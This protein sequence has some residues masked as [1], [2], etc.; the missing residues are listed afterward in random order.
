MI[1]TTA[2]LFDS[3]SQVVQAVE[4][5]RGCGFS[6]DEISMVTQK[7]KAHETSGN[8]AEPKDAASK[9]R[10]ILPLELG[11]FVADSQPRFMKGIGS[12]VMAGPLAFILMQAT[13]E[14]QC[15]DLMDALI[16]LDLSDEEAASYAEG[17]RRGG[18]LLTVS[19]ASYLAERAEDVMLLNGA[20]DIRQR[21]LRWQQHGWDTFSPNAEPCTAEEM[22]DERRRQATE[23]KPGR[24]WN[25]YDR[26][27]RSHFY[28][29]YSDGSLPYEAYAPAYRYGYQLASDERYDKKD[30]CEIEAHALQDWEK[31][32]ETGWRT[33]VDAISYGFSTG[34]VN[35]AHRS[36]Y[37]NHKE[38]VF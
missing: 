33:V 11:T 5:L 34:R 25:P 28:L 15:G 3:F 23:R 27:F 22:A 12:V 31:Q 36:T 20:V 13:D 18:T 1:T 17:V 37:R 24:Q 32:F 26:D 29:T 4:I 38:Y 6:R 14:T 9:Q 19:A 10:M 30:W 7:R 8:P 35:Y 2:S 21:T 16:D